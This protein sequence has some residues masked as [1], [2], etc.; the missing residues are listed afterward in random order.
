MRAAV[1]VIGFVMD[2]IRKIVLRSIGS[3]AST[4]LQPTQCVWTTSPSRQTSVAAP[5]RPPA[6]TIDPMAAAT[7]FPSVP[8]IALPFESMKYIIAI[9]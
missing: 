8:P 5:A 7:E 4:S 2:A 6:S 1:E 9:K 3:L